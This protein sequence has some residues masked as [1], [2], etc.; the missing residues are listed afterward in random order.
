LAEIFEL[1]LGAAVMSDNGIVGLLGPRPP[2]PLFATMV[3]P[4]PQNREEACA[5]VL[6]RYSLRRSILEMGQG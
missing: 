1:E 6:H 2:K 3:L 5:S 4:S